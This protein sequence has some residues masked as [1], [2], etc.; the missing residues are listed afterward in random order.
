M[1]VVL[2]APRSHTEQSLKQSVI[3]L[4]N[5][6]VNLFSNV[7]TA[8]PALLSRQSITLDCSLYQAVLLQDKA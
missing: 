4:I 8:P 1:R 2:I 3:Q 6:P 5:L 7:P